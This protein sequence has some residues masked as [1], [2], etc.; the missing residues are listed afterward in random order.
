MSVPRT[1]CFA[2]IAGNDDK[3]LIIG[4]TEAPVVEIMNFS[5]YKLYDAKELN[6]L[7]N[8]TFAQLCSYTVDINLKPCAMA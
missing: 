7:S 8:N 3:I 1:E 2:I 4:G 5:D 6:R